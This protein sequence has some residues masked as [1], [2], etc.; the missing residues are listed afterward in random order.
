MPTLSLKEGLEQDFFCRLEVGEHFK[1]DQ[2]SEGHYKETIA[3][4]CCI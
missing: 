2:R 4:T 1:Q 3:Y